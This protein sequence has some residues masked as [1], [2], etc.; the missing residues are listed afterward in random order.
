MGLEGEEREVRRSPLQAAVLERWWGGKREAVCPAAGSRLGARSRRAAQQWLQTHAFPKMYLA[1]LGIPTTRTRPTRRH[2]TSAC[3]CAHGHSL[4]SVQRGSLHTRWFT[5]P[6][7]LLPRAPADG[8]VP[9]LWP[10]ARQ[11]FLSRLTPLAPFLRHLSFPCSCCIAMPPWERSPAPSRVRAGWARRGAAGVL[12]CFGIAHMP[13]LAPT[14]LGAQV[15]NLGLSLAPLPASP[16][17]V[18]CAPS[19]SICWR[20]IL[21]GTIWRWDFKEAAKVK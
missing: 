18:N 7:Q 13:L 12:V 19:R 4:P 5:P 20:P 16:S 11:G 6:P 15:G 2:T 14:C 17:A 21:S 8:S 10:G 3:I 9:L 1:F